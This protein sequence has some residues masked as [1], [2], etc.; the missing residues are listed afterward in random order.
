MNTTPTVYPSLQNLPLARATEIL[1]FHVNFAHRWREVHDTPAVVAVFEAEGVAD[2][3]DN[4]LADAVCEHVLRGAIREAAV[5]G[6]L[7]SVGR[8]DAAVS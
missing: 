3:V 4:F 1:F 5:G 7:E 8:D 2:F 6:G